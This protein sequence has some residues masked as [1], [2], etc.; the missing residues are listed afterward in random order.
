MKFIAKTI[1]I[2]EA[3][4]LLASAKHVQD[5][6]EIEADRGKCPGIGV[7]N[8]FDIYYLCEMHIIEF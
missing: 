3:C 4:K 7:S 6:Q 2:L 8:I 1:L 5:I